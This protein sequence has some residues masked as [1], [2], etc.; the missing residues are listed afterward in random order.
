MH[1]YERIAREMKLDFSRV[2][3]T[4][5]LMDQGNTLPFIARYRKEVTGNLEDVKL[6]ELEEKLNLYRNLEERKDTVLRLLGEQGVL[7]E[8]M[9][10]ALEK[11]TSLQQIEDIYRPYRPKKR[12][13]A[14]IAVEKGLAELADYLLKED[15]SEDELLAYAQ[16]FI[17]EE[18]EVASVQEALVYAQD[19]IADRLSDDIGSRGIV[20]KAAFLKGLFTSSNQEEA[21]PVYEVYFDFSEP[22]RTMKPHQTLAIFRGEKEGSLKIG[23]DFPDEEIL[24]KLKPQFSGNKGDFAVYINEAVED[25]YKR[26][27]KPSIETEIRNA[28]KEIADTESIDVF[29]KNLRPYLMQ[30]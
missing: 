5:E 4:V 19:I 9:E 23:F 6:R 30:P 29:K 20:R 21:D 28:L 14:T 11:A 12:T 24:G 3:R 13:R 7:N 22:I 27:L 1:I 25:G 15:K 18:K 26:L 2:Q 10:L 17:S 16:E 8:E